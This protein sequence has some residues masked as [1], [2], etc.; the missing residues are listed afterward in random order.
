MTT[1]TQEFTRVFGTAHE[2]D[3]GQLY[4]DGW[5]QAF[6][7]TSKAMDVFRRFPDGHGLTEEGDA[8]VCSALENSGAV[9]LAGVR[10]ESGTTP[11]DHDTGTVLEIEGSRA[12]V[13]WDSQVRTW[14]PV[15]LL[16]IV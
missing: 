16:R 4:A 14:Q 5:P 6:S 7:Y 13:A 12:L 9:F 3:D 11:E 1:L 15:D 2:T 10:V 8:E